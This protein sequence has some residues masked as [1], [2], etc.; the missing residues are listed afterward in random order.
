MEMAQITALVER[1]TDDQLMEEMQRPSGMAPLQVVIAEIQRRSALRGGKPRGFAAG[2]PVEESRARSIWDIVQSTLPGARFSSGYRTP[3]RQQQLIAQGLPAARN[4]RHTSGRAVDW[5]MP[6]SMSRDQVEGS[7]RAR[8]L[9]FEDVIYHPENNS[10]HVEMPPDWE[11]GGAQPP[12]PSSPPVMADG[13]FPDPQAITQQALSIGDVVAGRMGLPAEIPGLPAQ[14]AEIQSMMPDTTGAYDSAIKRLQEAE[15]DAM[16]SSRGRPFIDAG[17]AM[18]TAQTPDFMSALGQGGM[19]GFSARDRI[20]EQQRG[21]MNAVIQAQLAKSQTE[22][23][24]ARASLESAANIGASQ[25]GAM[26]QAYETGAGIAGRGGQIAVAAAEDNTR[27]ELSAADIAARERIARMDAD[28]RLDLVREQA[29]VQAASDAKP[30]Q[31]YQRILAPLLAKV[32]ERMMVPGPD[33]KPSMKIFTEEDAARLAQAGT[34]AAMAYRAGGSQ[35]QAPA[36]V[37]SNTPPPQ[38]DWSKY[39]RD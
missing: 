34:E 4:S 26:S 20:Q 24:N 14:F 37:A 3:E 8:G 9:P 17:L 6:G 2:G 25:R 11:P 30:E 23:Q 28:S 15:K 18:M 19:A 21:L 1:L 38:R 12:A 27:R 29:R 13:S 7:L 10:W 5:T 36:P 39:Q 22:A 32:G 31:I 16:R 35:Q 33:G